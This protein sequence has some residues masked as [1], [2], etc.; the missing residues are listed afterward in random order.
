[1]LAAGHTEPMVCYRGIVTQPV[2]PLALAATHLIP[3]IK[4]FDDIHV[5]F[6]FGNHRDLPDLADFLFGLLMNVGQVPDDNIR[7]PTQ[8]LATLPEA[9]LE[10][11]AFWHMGGRG[12]THQWH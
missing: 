5:R 6:H 8:A 7:T 9:A 1:M 4:G 11:I 12:P 2:Q 10:Q 3:V